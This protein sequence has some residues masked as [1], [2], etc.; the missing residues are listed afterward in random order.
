MPETTLIQKKS[1]GRPA[2]EAGLRKDC[3]LRF[4]TSTAE[5]E[6]L[7]LAA[8]LCG[9]Q[10]RGSWAISRLLVLANSVIRH[11]GIDPVDERAVRE[12]LEQLDEKAD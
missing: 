4:R 12:S 6:A 7:D 2:L 10:S 5:M 11:A 8:R 1:R 9:F 3:S